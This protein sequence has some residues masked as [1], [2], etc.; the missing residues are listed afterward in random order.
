MLDHL[1]LLLL[2]APL[3]DK[4][5]I[6]VSG[7]AGWSGLVERGQWTPLV[8]DLEHRGDQDVDAELLVSWA[9]PGDVQAEKP[10]LAGLRGL[11]GP[12][13]RLPLSLGPRSRRRLSLS[14]RAPTNP[15]LHAWVFVEKS[16]R[17]LAAGEILARTADP[18]RRLVVTVGTRAANGLSAAGLLPAAATP[19][20]LPEDWRGYA[21]VEAVVWLDA[22][23]SDLRS[24]AQA[25]ALAGWV[26]AGGTL[27]V[28]RSGEAGL[29]GT[30]LADLLPVAVN[31]ARE[32]TL[33]ALSSLGPPA[34]PGRALVLDSTLLR[35]SALL[36]QGERPLVASVP[37]GA[38]RVVFLAFDV[39]QAPFDGWSGAPNFWT[40]LLRPAPPA[41]PADPDQTRR[42]PAALGSLA[43]AGLAG[44]FPDIPPP[45]L[46][47]LFL[48]IFA[49]L[50]VVGPL[51]YFL[52]R[53]LRRL[54]W[55]WLTFPAYVLL[56][57]AIILVAGGA[58]LERPAIQR[59]IAV[60][61]RLPDVGLARR[62]AVAAVLA[63]RASLFELRGEP[64]SSNYL[65]RALYG[66]SALELGHPR[67]DR[68]GGDMT[69]KDWTV[70][71]GATALATDDR[72]EP[73][74]PELTFEPGPDGT[75]SVSNAGSREIPGAMLVTAAGAAP[76]PPIPPGRSTLS[77]GA[78]QELASLRS[79][80][81]LVQETHDLD[82]PEGASDDRLDGEIRTL[83]L[84]LSFAPEG[85][86]AGFAKGLDA[87]AWL[88]SGGAVL[89]WWEPADETTVAFS[90]R[91]SRRSGVRMVR[92]FGRAG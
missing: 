10:I 29:A 62:R 49:Y 55:T 89:V 28:S 63:P 70:E 39:T 27:A 37:R 35:G 71:R 46:G 68:A 57:T 60:E 17:T 25:D 52:L 14:L 36:R 80:Q 72:L 76:L 54:E 18:A 78:R 4:Q 77:P 65:T 13:H 43:L 19:E 32:D 67:L 7:H 41:P 6:L 82:V 30:P 59:E 75:L 3:Q 44:R 47:G 58:F 56:F 40:W 61:D 15:G 16:G 20:H 90:P 69:L 34:P 66:E 38:G 87:G 24:Q 86:R 88:R 23:A 9:L 74:A 12:V 81:H 45:E 73:A 11:A 91:P 92:V 1:F 79:P 42:A 33:E 53:G 48:L 8:V 85:P 51:D 5:E 26:A 64:V 22:R 50:A 21:G 84:H 31:G 83:L 2:A